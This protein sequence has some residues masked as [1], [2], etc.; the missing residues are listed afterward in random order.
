MPESGSEPLTARTTA[1]AAGCDNSSGVNFPAPPPSAH[2]AALVEAALDQL[3]AVWAQSNESGTVPVSPSQ[4]RAMN[5]VEAAG[6]INMGG[7]A[8]ELG[9]VPSA[10]SRLCDR[11][12]AAGLLERELSPSSRRE[13]VLRLS[14]HG[15][16][17]LT[18]LREERIAAVDQVLKE[19]TPAAQRSLVTGLQ[20]FQAAARLR[21]DQRGSSRRDD[22]KASLRAGPELAPRNVPMVNI[23]LV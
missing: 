15:G 16:R 23:C 9:T 21:D 13:V 3:Q 1:L 22:G 11:M 7:L 14:P 10:A 20:A 12:V 4:M 8:S 18:R 2:W 6:E 19:M 17:L 5:I